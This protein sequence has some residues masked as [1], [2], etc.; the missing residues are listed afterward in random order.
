ML[1]CCCLTHIQYSIYC[2]CVRQQQHLRTQDSQ[3]RFRILNRVYSID[4]MQCCSLKNFVFAILALG[5]SDV[6]SIW[7]RLPSLDSCSAR[8]YYIRSCGEAIPSPRQSLVGLSKRR[9]VCTQ[10]KYVTANLIQNAQLSAESDTSK[11]TNRIKI[12]SQHLYCSK[13]PPDPDLQPEDFAPT[14]SSSRA[15]QCCSTSAQ[16]YQVPS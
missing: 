15:A 6:L 3:Y 12:S 4:V 5:R 1:C 10:R 7:H 2:I 11:Y 9:P 8:Y 16:L 14:H 13:H